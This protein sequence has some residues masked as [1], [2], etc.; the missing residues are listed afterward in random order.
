MNPTDSA[1]EPVLITGIGIVSPLGPTRETTWQ[2]ILAGERAGQQLDPGTLGPAWLGVRNDRHWQ[3]CPARRTGHR[4]YPCGTESFGHEPFVTDALTAAR[5]ALAH[6][7]L[8]ESGHERWGC[9]IGASKGGLHQVIPHWMQTHD[10]G[11]SGGLRWPGTWPNAPAAAV[12]QDWEVEGPVLAPAAACATGLVSLIRGAELI[13][14]RVCDVVLAGSTD[15]SLQP[16]L[17]GCYHRMGVMSRS[18]DPLAACK[19]FDR[20]RDGFLVGEGASI[21][22]LESQSHATR[23]EATVWA[24]F[25]T[26]R[27][28]SGASGMTSLD[29]SAEG[30]TRAIHDLLMASGLSL[31]M[32][33]LINWH[34]TG[35]RQN[36]RTE[37]TA[38]LSCLTGRPWSG[39]SCAFKG[40]LGHLMGG[41]GSVE[42][43][44]CVLALRDQIVPPT[45][46]LTHFDPELAAAEPHQLLN[47]AA[48]FVQHAQP[49]TIRTVMKTSLG[50]GGPVATALLRRPG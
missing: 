20:D 31:D 1:G 46:N 49:Q 24:E 35:T 48:S 42:T 29:E 37:I 26:G 14:T 21:L 40:A 22:V 41:A 47:L 13:R 7:G 6:A 3:G 8:S 18:S 2:A 15:A 4:A 28:L 23:R 36:D 43:A 39:H 33:D 11:P 34:G 9:V 27:S 10:W 16:A 32:I 50:F 30:L 25:V 17:L 45:A 12:A 38:L 19:P 44:L 5:E